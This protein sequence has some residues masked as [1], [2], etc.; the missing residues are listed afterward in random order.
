MTEILYVRVGNRDGLNDFVDLRGAIQH[1]QE[2]QV[3]KPLQRYAVTGLNSKLYFDANC[4]VIYWGTPRDKKWKTHSRTRCLST[5]E[6]QEIEDSLAH[7]SIL[8]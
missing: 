4:V 6:L 7:E 5:Q 2:K 8:E 1:L 3:T